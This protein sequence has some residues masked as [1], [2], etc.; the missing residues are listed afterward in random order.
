VHLGVV[1]VAV[2]VVFGECGRESVP[3]PVQKP[4][5]LCVHV[6]AAEDVLLFGEEFP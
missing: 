3:R 6:V 5:Q 1:L 2:L 4:F